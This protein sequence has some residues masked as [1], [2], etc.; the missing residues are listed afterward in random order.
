MLL[1]YE[2]AYECDGKPLVYSGAEQMLLGV[3]GPAQQAW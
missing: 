1:P 3:G 2:L